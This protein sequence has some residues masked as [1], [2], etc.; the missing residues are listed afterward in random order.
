MQTPA[1]PSGDQLDWLRQQLDQLPGPLH[2]VPDQ[3]PTV[4]GELAQRMLSAYRVEGGHVHLAGCALEDRPLIRVT[5]RVS[6]SEPSGE[7]RLADTL[8]DAEGEIVSKTIAEALDLAHLK[9]REERPPRHDPAQL[10]RLLEQARRLA[11]NKFPESETLAA[12]VVWCKHAEGKLSFVLGDAVAEVRF[13]GWARTLSP[14]PLV[15]AFSGRSSYHVVATDD[16]RIAVAEAIGTCEVTG[17]RVL[18]DEM[19]T[20]SLTGKR[21]VAE[22]LATCPVC[23]ERLL[24]EHLVSCDCCGQRVSPQV[25]ERATCRAC[26][27]TLRIR[28]AD[29]RMACVLDEYPRLDHYRNW[30]L[31]ETTTHYILI[32]G[33]LLRRTLVV[34]EKQTLSPVHVA[35]RSR[36]FSEWTVVDSA[37]WS[38]ILGTAQRSMGR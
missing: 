17:A 11:Q 1:E 3:Q 26:R 2:S 6:L 15:C 23:D 13:S 35:T 31:S 27:Q 38:D 7:S 21:V 24:S 25:V 4:A 16:G 19:A 14:P 20:C 28:K 8:V 33:S 18:L 22:R 9:R 32:A 30:K 10:Q 37:H 5:S 34:L 12:T 29:P 36:F